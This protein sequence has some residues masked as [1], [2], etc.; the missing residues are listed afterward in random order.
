MFFCVRTDLKLQDFQQ[1]EF[2]PNGKRA[3]LHANITCS[4]S[5][6]F[7]QKL[8]QGTTRALQAT[9]RSTP[10]ITHSSVNYYA[11]ITAC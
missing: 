1:A 8:S 7:S 4:I 2:S 5:N 3:F 9:F 6:P 11:L 10:T